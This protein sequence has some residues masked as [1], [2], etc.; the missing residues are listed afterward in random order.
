MRITP[1]TYVR[2]IHTDLTNEHQL[3]F[4]SLEE[5]TLYF[6]SLNGLVL[7]DFTYQRK[8]NIIRYPRRI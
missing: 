4:E 6:E 7:D 5:Q 2:L 1:N 8:D 3:T